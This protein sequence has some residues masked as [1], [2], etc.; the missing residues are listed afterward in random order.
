MVTFELAAVNLRDLE[1]H[2]YSSIV[3][4][5]ADIP[6]MEWFDYVISASNVF[7]HYRR[8]HVTEFRV[9]I[10]VLTRWSCN[11]AN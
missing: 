7:F 8:A 6:D 1:V 2:L 11:G 10:T 3:G 4:L 9:S 5:T